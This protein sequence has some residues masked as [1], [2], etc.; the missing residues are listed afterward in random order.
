MS[1]F[2]THFDLKHRAIA[3]LS[4]RLFNNFSYTIRHGLAAG[5]KR[6]GGLGFLPFKSEETEESRYLAA[7]PLNGKTV[8]DVGGF[9]GV[10]T[11]FFARK[12]AAVVTFEPNPRN[13][14]R[15]L[16]NVKLNKLSNVRVLNRGLSDQSGSIELVFDPLM[17]GATSGNQEIAHQ[18]AATVSKART[19]E[20]PVGTLDVDAVDLK[21]PAPDFIKID[22]EGMELPA[23][24]GMAATLQQYGPE[25]F[26]ELHGAELEDKIRNAVGVI[27]YLEDAGYRCFDVE[28]SRYV[29]SAGL[30]SAPS[31][32]HCT[33]QK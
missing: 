11:L 6:K 15:C 19:I 17:P 18:I 12:A 4:T 25:L 30:T 27:A 9:E 13:Y 28:N 20:I 22:I 10:L 21:L 32:L 8:Y 33:K 3:F 1:S 16:D 31:H 23:L 26:I 14:R 7:L 5:M 2:H 24:R 29:T